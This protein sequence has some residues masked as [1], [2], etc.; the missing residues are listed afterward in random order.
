MLFKHTVSST[1]SCQGTDM[2]INADLVS[3]QAKGKFRASSDQMSLPCCIMNEFFMLVYDLIASL[4][5][6]LYRGLSIQGT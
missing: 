4:F 2:V 1:M 3:G 5:A 6:S